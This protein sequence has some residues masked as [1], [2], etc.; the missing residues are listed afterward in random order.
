M[1]LFMF[2]KNYVLKI[3]DWTS[4]TCT[5]KG[6]LEE[7]RVK[8]RRE[9]T[10]N[11]LFCNKGP[12]I[13]PLFAWC[14]TTL[15]FLHL[16]ELAIPLVQVIFFYFFQNNVFLILAVWTFY[17]FDNN[18][19]YNKEVGGRNVSLINKEFCLRIVVVK[20]GSEGWAPEKAI[21]FSELKYKYVCVLDILL[22]IYNIC[23]VKKHIS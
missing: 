21:S 4:C 2:C 23:T 7:K 9:E 19:T 10:E 22:S 11:S 15:K 20:T 6:N 18:L 14:E 5:R 3:P 13:R 8:I 1:K 16:G 17:F 12:K